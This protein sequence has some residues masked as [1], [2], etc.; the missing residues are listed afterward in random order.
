VAVERGARDVLEGF[1]GSNL[2]DRLARVERL[3]AELPL[4]LRD[5]ATGR[6]R[7]GRIDLLYRDRDGEVVVADF[8]T[9]RAT[10]DETLRLRYAGQMGVYAEAVRLGLGLAE[11]PR[12]ELWL[13]RTGRIVT[14]D[15]PRA[16]PEHGRVRE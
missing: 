3:G 12:A 4:L 15:P 5:D 11:R 13:L 2:P 8:K 7:R 16:D 1:L 10:D 14:V 6:I 9:D